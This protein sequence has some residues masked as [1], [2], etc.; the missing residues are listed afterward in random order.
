MTTHAPRRLPGI[1]FSVEPPPQVA[2]PRMDVAAFVGL[3]AMGPLDTP[4]PIEDAAQFRALFG[5]APRLAWDARAGAE[6]VAALAGAVQDFFAQGGRRCW[7]VRVAGAARFGRFPLAGLLA[8][9]PAGYVAATARARSPGSW[10]DRLRAGASLLVEPAVLADAAVVAGA[11]F[12][13]ELTMLRGAP[14]RSGD[15]L[16]LDSGEGARG[17]VLVETASDGNTIRDRRQQ[18]RGPAFWFEAADTLPPTP[19]TVHSVPFDATPS[20]A[21]DATLAGLALEHAV[22]HDE[23]RVEPGD[24]LRFVPAAGGGAIWLLAASATPRATQLRAAWRE[25]A[26]GLL[27]ASRAMRVTVALAAYD[28]QQPI[29]VAR[30]LGLAAPHPRHWAALPDD[31]ARFRDLAESQRLDLSGDTALFPLAG[32]A[33]AAQLYL[34]LGLDAVPV[35]LRGALPDTAPPLQRDGLLPPGADPMAI[36]SSAW[37]TFL[38]AI[39][40]DPQLRLVGPGALLAE[41]TELRSLPGR[42]LRGLHGLAQ[43]DEVSLLALPDAAQR[44]WRLEERARVVITPPP[45]PPSPVDPCAP[46]G[47]FRP[48]P[49]TLPAATPALP[50]TLALSSETERFWALLPELSYDA[51]GL[52]ELHRQAAALATARGDMVAVLGLPTHYG[53]AEALEHRRQLGRLLRDSGAE[54]SY[55]ALYHPGLLFRG[56]EGDVQRRGPDGAVCGIVAA[57]SLERGAWIAPANQP[58]RGALALLPSLGADD[59]AA[60]YAAGINIIRPDARGPTLW[61]A[62]TLSDDPQLVPLNVRRLLILLRRVVLRDGQ[63]FVFAPHGPAFRRRI[64]LQLERI[65]SLLFERGAFA[66]RERA[67]AFQVVIDE[68]L[69]T[70]P[71]VAQGR[72][73]VELR[74]A[75]ARPLEF[76][77]VRLIESG[78]GTIVAQEG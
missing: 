4:V 18:V 20:V 47:T 8:V 42:G 73:L 38:A 78:A 69:N 34:P 7:V 44:G 39:H 3:A 53:A 24:W 62:Q 57:R 33:D 36:D 27:L 5:P 71:S 17:Y 11:S 75:P 50:E 64:A 37:A 15:L 19:G 32:P 31:A 29:G 76:I 51:A 60:L 55:A 52:L 16:Q 28:E 22:A 1:S 30:E 61:S 6:H 14:L 25:G 10:S 9:T 13:G 66:G 63:E 49:V 54:P 46:T 48:R 2:L 21:W 43:I 41:A 58:A 45:T 26:P 40:L 67:A 65:L 77:V 72:L 70:P 68:Q 35:A 56:T 59:L 74:V 23:L 12:A